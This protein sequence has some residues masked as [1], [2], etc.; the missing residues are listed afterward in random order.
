M[1]HNLGGDANRAKASGIAGF[2]SAE[3]H[4]YQIDRQAPGLHLDIN[5]IRTDQIQRAKMY[6]P[7]VHPDAVK[8]GK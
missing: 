1:L 3:W 2:E 8:P 5:Y 4:E 7:P 6:S